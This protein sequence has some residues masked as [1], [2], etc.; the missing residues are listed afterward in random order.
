M[1]LL[2]T[3]WTC[4]PGF[5]KGDRSMISSVRPWTRPTNLGL[6]AGG[7]CLLALCLAVVS[8]AGAQEDNRWAG[9]DGLVEQGLKDWQVPGLA[10]AVVKDGKVVY[11]RGYGVRNL[12]TREGVNPDTLFYIGS[13]TKSFTATLIAALAEEGKVSWDRPL[14]DT[15]PDFQMFDP[16]ATGKT[17][18]RDLLCHRTGIPRQEF[19]K[20][21]APPKRTDLIDRLRFFEPTTDFR[22][23]FQ[24]CNETVTVA[25][26]LLARRAETTWETLVRSRLLEPLGMSRS[27]VRVEEM[28]KAGN[29]A[30]PYIIRRNGTEELAFYDV[31]E[32][33]GPAGG[34]ISSVNDLAR[35]VIF[36]L[37]RGKWEG[38]TL[39]S[40]EYLA[41]L[42]VPQMPAT[43]SAPPYSELTHQSYGL[44]WFIDSYR[45]SL[46][47]FHPGNLYGFSAL[48]SFL[49]REN[50][51]VVVLANLNGTKLVDII[52][53]FVYDQLLGLPA[54]DWNVRLL[55]D[56]SKMRAAAAA[57]SPPS[58]PDRKPAAR[59]SHPLEAYSGA[60]MNPGYGTLQI[61]CERETLTITVHSGTFPLRHYNGDSF[62]FYHPVEDQGWLLLFQDDALGHITSIHLEPG[63][64]AKPIAF[65]R[66]P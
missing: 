62:E 33:R 8:P 51:G 26:D 20:V 27:A 56:L 25:G 35:W 28:K 38:K 44:G 65:T 13:A 16:A 48:V 17:T 64:G 18:F 4:N 57:Q 40:P 58:D 55:G 1:S 23:G 21:H 6:A 31:A 66:L 52:E 37:N 61:G 15:F 49:P 30:F 43:R 10:L 19:L 45:G 9:L 34:I 3:L 24:Y 63:P 32:L 41:Q 12:Q 50:A 7:L 22:Y 5:S 11:A 42:W 39:I 36:N 14:R 54:V 46:R 59:P 2:F 53:R 29:H 47:I 60:F